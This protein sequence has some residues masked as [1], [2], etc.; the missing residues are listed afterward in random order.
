MRT[1]TLAVAIAALGCSGGFPI[2]NRIDPTAPTTNDPA[3]T[4]RG[5]QSWYLIG[6]GATAG[7]GP[8]DVRSSPRRRAPTSSTPTS[9]AA[10]AAHDRAGRRLRRSISRSPTLPAGAHEILFSANG[11]RRRIR[12][13]D[14]QSQ[15][16]RIT[17]SCRPTTTFPIP[18]I[19]AIGHMDKLHTD[20]PG[21][22]ITH[23]WAPY[24]Y[25]D[26]VVTRRSA[27]TSSTRGSRSS[28]T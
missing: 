9:P 25:T 21:M 24:T 13:G 1:W 2:Q 11:S 20:H 15:R 19:S 4:S 14:A 3:F 22:V 5:L 16:C 6:D 23:F 8:A 12:E 18:G 17:C 27:A 28:A 26:P 7:R 10:A